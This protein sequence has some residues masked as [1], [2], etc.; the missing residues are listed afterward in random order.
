M[1]V[2]RIAERYAKSLIDLA[3]DSGKLD[4]VYNDALTLKTAM[5]NR[6]LYLML[7]SPI[8]NVGKKTAIVKEI[9]QNKIDATTMAF[10]QII[11]NKGREAYLPE[12]ANSAIEQYNTLNGKSTVKI[13]TAVEMD[14]AW[15]EALKKKIVDSGITSSNIEVQSKIDPSLIGGFVIEVGDKILN[16]SVAYKLDQLKKEFVVAQ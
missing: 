9:F 6:D 2:Q 16:A 3:K 14:A 11:L 12:I 13:T 10:L 1:S 8:I 4:T 5:T 15:W 7:K